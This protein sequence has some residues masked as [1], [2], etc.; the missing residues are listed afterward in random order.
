M[1]LETD[2]DNCRSD[3]V[4]RR[5]RLIVINPIFIGLVF[6]IMTLL[7]VTLA[8]GKAKKFDSNHLEKLRNTNSCNSCDLREADFTGANLLVAN[9]GGANVS[10]ADFS[11][12][13]LSGVN[14]IGANLRGANFAEANLLG[15]NLREADLR[16]ANFYK[17]DLGSADLRDT[18]L[19]GVNFFRTD[20]SD[21]RLDGANI[22][23]ARCRPTWCGPNR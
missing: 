12:A 1:N 11:L 9:L 3:L 15:A 4:A 18:N 5:V 22:N 16:D 7:F 20:L 23:K 6:T 2:D 14:L 17:A 13:N 8:Y 10:G 21:A 19:Q